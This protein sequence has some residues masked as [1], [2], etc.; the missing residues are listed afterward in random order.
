MSKRGKTGGESGPK[1]SDPVSHV[2]LT[3]L[4]DTFKN[5]VSSHVA[6]STANLEQRLNGS[7]YNL[8]RSYDAA[9]QARFLAIQNSVSNLDVTRQAVSRQQGAV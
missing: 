2:Q 6:A 1:P 3:A 5:D 7:V 9:Q 8:I 4:L